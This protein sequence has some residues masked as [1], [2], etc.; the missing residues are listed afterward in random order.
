[1]DRIWNRSLE[2]DGEF[3]KQDPAKPLKSKKEAEISIPIKTADAC[4]KLCAR[5]LSK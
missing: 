1:M 3:F 4:V 5:L 2:M